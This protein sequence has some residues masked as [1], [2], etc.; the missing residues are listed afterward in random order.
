M[1]PVN[2]GEG[3]PGRRREMRPTPEGCRA[4]S[5]LLVSESAKRDEEKP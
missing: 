2:G 3:V 5:H 1:A 4:V